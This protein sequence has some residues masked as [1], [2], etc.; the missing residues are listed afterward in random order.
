MAGVPAHHKSCGR[1]SLL[2]LVLALLLGFP[3]LAA[4]QD[5]TGLDYGLALG[6][7]ALIV[8]DW[9]QTLQIARNPDRWS[10]GN[11]LIGQHPSEGHVNTMMTLY[12]AWNAAA[13]LLPKTP[14]RI[15]Y[16][17]VTVVEAVAV[18]HN[19]SM[20]ISIGF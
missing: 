18:A 2:L 1:A 19:L 3:R 5:R 20:G 6:S 12:V 15:W 9:S 7:T 11:P 17:A 8:A 4:S 16:I 10:E 14:R 13:L